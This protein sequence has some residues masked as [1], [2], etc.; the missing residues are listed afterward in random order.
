M[1][2]GTGPFLWVPAQPSRA[3]EADVS[4]EQ[5]IGPL[6]TEELAVIESTLLPASNRHHLRILAHGLRSL[7]DA[8][9]R[10]NGHL[11]SVGD[12]EQWVA[13]QPGMGAE[14]EFVQVFKT[15][16]QTL[17]QQLELISS[18]YGCAP[19]DLTLQQLVDWSINQAKQSL[20]DAGSL[21]SSLQQQPTHE[22]Q[23]T[24]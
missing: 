19:L 15:Q 1:A 6:S 14:P 22:Q 17:G 9:G 18:T 4:A 7:Q 10:Q 3:K 16:L 13:A 23:D 12:L 20:I 5:Q 24:D 2:P 8:A 21:R 11:P